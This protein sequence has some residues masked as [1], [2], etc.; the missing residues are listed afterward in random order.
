MVPIA[1]SSTNIRFCISSFMLLIVDGC[2][3][4]FKFYF[5]VHAFAF[6]RKNKKKF[7]RKFR[8]ENTQRA[9]RKFWIYNCRLT[10]FTLS[11]FLILK[12]IVNLKSKIV[13]QFALG[14]EAIS[15]LKKRYSEKPDPQG[16]ALQKGGQA[17]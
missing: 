3:C 17:Q 14:I 6:L 8:K 10:N 15:F 5:L 2:C 13:N 7:N 11:I 4:V 9:Q 1:P 12:Q 16:N